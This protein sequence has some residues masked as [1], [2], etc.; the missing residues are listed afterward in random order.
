MAPEWRMAAVA[1]VRLQAMHAAALGAARTLVWATKDL[2]TLTR[3][4]GHLSLAVLLVAVVWSV[5][6]RSL[7]TPSSSASPS[8]QAVDTPREASPDANAVQAN[9]RYLEHGSAPLTI[10][11]MRDILP[12]ASL[13]RVARTS[14]LTYKV[15]TG[16]T[17]LDIAERF[18][19][20]GTSLLYANDK[21]MDNPD[22]LWLG[23]ELI[24]LPVDGAY[25]TVAAG[26]TVDS[27]GAKYKVDPSS[28]SGF[29][30]NNLQPPYTLKA[31]MKLIIPDGT[32]PYVPKVV[33]AYQG[34]VPA[35]ARKGTGGFAWP[36][37][38]VITQRYWE[39]HQAVDIGAPMGTPV[40]AADSGFV[41]V[42][43]SSNTGYGR[44][45]VIDHGNGFS[46]LYAHLNAYIVD[47]GQSVAKGEVIAYCGR[48]GNSTGPHLHFELVLGGV[49]RNPLGFLP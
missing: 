12:M 9:T 18:G 19:L 3:F 49:R 6:P 46:T 22:F 45:V 16:D 20:K 23:Q 32:K 21:L 40:V 15:E 24:I 8:P 4:A 28:I 36:M 47:P 5:D 29:V 11:V 27:I 1:Q 37:S 25:H 33:V 42:I 39:G 34:P 31:G 43:Q 7:V 30:G 41:A 2:P 13:K 14:V 48:T 38:G 26:E 35:G 17:L 44:M 10:R